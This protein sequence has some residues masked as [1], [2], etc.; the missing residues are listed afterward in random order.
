M[1]SLR[2][3]FLLFLLLV[4]LQ[5][6]VSYSQQIL[7]PKH[8]DTVKTIRPVEIQWSTTLPN[9]NYLLKYIQN[10]QESLIV[11]SIS[12]ASSYSWQVPLLDTT[13]VSLILQTNSKDFL[14]PILWWK[15]DTVVVP[16]TEIRKIYVTSSS[17]TFLF[18]TI[19]NSIEEWDISNSQRV[20][21]EIFGV[22]TNSQ[23]S[24]SNDKFTVL[25]YND[26]LYYIDRNTRAFTSKGLDNP[27][28]SFIRDIAYSTVTDLIATASNDG[29]IKIRNLSTDQI[30]ATI[31]VPTISSMYSVSFS[32]DGQ[33]IVFAG[34]DGA[35]YVSNLVS[36]PNYTQSFERHGSAGLGLVVWDCNFSPDDNRIVSGGVDG[37]VKVWESANL[38]L[39]STM[40]GHTFHVRATYFS[41][42]NNYIASVGLDSSLIIF[43]A[44]S[45]QQLYQPLKHPHALLCMQFFADSKRIITAGRGSTVSIW[46][47]PT[48]S[49]FYDTIIV[50]PKYPISIY[51]PTITA[52]VGD[53][54]S[55]P[56]NYSVQSKYP[57]I[58]DFAFQSSVSRFVFSPTVNQWTKQVST[59]NLF[60]SSI[61]TPLEMQSNS[62]PSWRA[63]V[64]YSP[65]KNYDSL[66]ISNIRFA[67]NFYVIDSIQ[68][69]VVFIDSLC[70]QN[71]NYPS[72]SLQESGLSLQINSTKEDIHF[73][74]SPIEIG[75][76]ILRI[77][78]IDGKEIFKS[79]V[80]VS[81]NLDVISY[82]LSTHELPKLYLISLIS[83]TEHIVKKVLLQ[84]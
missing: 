19:Y 15:N 16:S 8:F 38:N 44:N 50:L 7:F 34:N 13:D 1:N 2:I 67:N 51:I 21:S 48:E 12:L 65:Y 53:R 72:I 24:F 42:D 4:F 5:Y 18:S 35:I 33:K 61:L 64:L 82:N 40:T 71:S 41:P 75:S 78:S 49:I 25:G 31:S 77:S 73:K 3:E 56:I 32:N 58:V 81:K 37:T 59:G 27:H 80:D 10:N 14:Q 63:T 20:V 47:L 23:A 36:L 17:D 30:I 83:P 26:V 43:D 29:T 84:Q 39:L 11:N 9:S 6:H 55:V 52:S 45:Y 70:I 60:E 79:T 69:G 46:Q 66:I 28:T 68:N 62:L 57:S 74:V 22:Q 76:H 54:I